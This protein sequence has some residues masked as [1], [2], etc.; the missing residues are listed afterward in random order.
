MAP[1]SD[2]ALRGVTAPGKV[3]LV[4]EY[5]VLRG[6]V[7]VLAALEKRCVATMGENANASPL[8]KSVL[9]NLPVPG[10][11]AAK[12]VVDSREFYSSEGIKLGIGSSAA[13]AVVAS[14]FALSHERQADLDQIIGV[15][16]K[17]HGDFQEKKGAR[18]SGVDI[19]ASAVGGVVC[20]KADG[21][22]RSICLP[23]GFCFDLAW[24][25][26]SSSSADFVKRMTAFETEN[27]SVAKG[28]FANVAQASD[29]FVV[30]CEGKNTADAIGSLD[31][32]RMAISALGE[33][34]NLPIE[35]PFHRDLN[36]KAKDFGGLAKTVG[37]GGGDVCLCAFPS[38][39]ALAEFKD[40]CDVPFLGVPISPHGLQFF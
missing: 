39:D 9:G 18:G 4:G 21:D 28:L 5:A 31:M 33:K 35:L 34:S 29:S 30:A 26:T 17:A 22:Y 27:Q 1:K 19:I 6:G 10:E 15:A 20:A 23:P 8:I 11:E 16:R 13:T 14:A 38:L 3:M 25:G 40:G 7:A 2:T 32:V 36:R 12:V 24:T 37:A